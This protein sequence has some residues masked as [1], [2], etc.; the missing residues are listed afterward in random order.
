MEENK[1]I[2]SPT[3][4]MIVIGDEI[5]SGRTRDLNGHW[6]SQFLFSQGLTLKSLRFVKDN[7]V[8]IKKALDD[9]FHDSEI[10]ITSGG[11]GPTIDDKTKATLASYFKKN[12]IE[13]ND[14][15]SV[16]TDNY[17]RF[18]RQWTPQTNRYH[19]FPED[20]ICIPNPKGLAPGLG[21]L[22]PSKKLLLAAPGVPREFTEMVSLE[23]FPIIKKYFNERILKNYQT[24]IRTQGIPE[25]KIFF[26]LCPTLWQDLE[27]FGSVSSLPHT[28][29]IDIVVSFKGNSQIFEE[30]NKKIKELIEQTSL[31]SY[32]WQWGNESINEMV[33]NLAKKLNCSF[34]FAESCT[35]GLT[36]SKITDLPGA[37]QVFWGSIISYDNSVKEQ[38]LNVKSETIKKHGAV[39]LEVAREMALGLKNKLN[40]D[41]AISLTGIA[42]P[43]GGSLEKPVGLVAIGLATKD[44][45]SAQIF[46]FPGD[47]LKLKDRFSD[48]AL[49]TL[50][51]IL[52]ARE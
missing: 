19:F 25:E 29:G 42:G 51:E 9:S 27:V 30:K 17:Q 46:Q 47:R 48:K 32:V 4:S 15:V 1:N 45:N 37:S 41:V 36:S 39:S 16:I 11:V 44:Q 35:G 22:T 21:F 33:L 43:D 50:Y 49:L 34:G 24:V 12:I 13:R 38:S 23:F 10:V 7:E 6:L 31:S 18:G 40:V 20:F 52:K 8:E 28:L 2:V 3:V 14:V 26:E 5:L